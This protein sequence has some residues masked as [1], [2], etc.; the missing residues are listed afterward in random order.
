MTALSYAEIKALASGNPAIKEKMDLDISVSKL[1]L[2][3][4]SFLNQKY[5]LENKIVKYYP[6]EIKD[7]EK[8]ISCYEKDMERVKKY[9]PVL[10]DT[11]P[12]MEIQGKLYE[13]KADA[14]KALIEACKSMTS[15]DEISIGSYRGMQMGLFF[16]SFSKEYEL[17]LRGNQKYQVTLGADIYGNIT[18]IDN[19][20]NGLED[21][22]KNCKE[23]LSEIRTQ[24]EN[25]KREVEKPFSKEDEL[26]EKSERLEELNAL[27][28][29][30][31][32]N[33]SLLGIED[34]QSEPL[35]EE[36][37]KTGIQER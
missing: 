26:R 13:E 36:R 22:W 1:Q 27:L 21:K 11:F 9:T 34:D 3:K 6:K 19:A 37:E 12:V 8:R 14:G 7:M 28:N 23:K 31:E 5:E 17:I 16:N 24:Y 15:P 32:K 20:I 4:Q 33:Q 10:R 18:R 2:L 29:M 35:S 25:A 30:G